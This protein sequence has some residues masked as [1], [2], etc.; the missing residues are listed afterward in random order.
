M[1]KIPY[2]KAEQT[3]NKLVQQ[4]TKCV[5]LFTGEAREDG[6]NWCPDCENIAPLYNTFE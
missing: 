1:I 6:S 4:K 5:V 2:N 3:F